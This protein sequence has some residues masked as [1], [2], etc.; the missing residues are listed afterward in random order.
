MF[1]VKEINQGNNVF[2]LPAPAPAHKAAVHWLQIL[3]LVKLAFSAS[4]R[5]CV[6][7]GRHRFKI[8]VVVVVV[9][10]VQRYLSMC[11]AHL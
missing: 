3:P 1:Y 4:L 2:L 5:C 11:Q 8:D 7:S 10:T 9:S 6:C